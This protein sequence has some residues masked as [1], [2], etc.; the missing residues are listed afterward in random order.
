MKEICMRDTEGVALRAICWSEICPWLSIVRCFRLATTL[1]LLVFGACA[2]LFTL[3][4][5]WAIARIFGSDDHPNASWSEAF[6]DLSPTAVIDR[7]IPA[8]PLVQIPSPGTDGAAPTFGSGNSGLAASTSNPF[9]GPWNELTRPVW[10]IFVGP[11]HLP[12]EA[13][14]LRNLLS[15]ACTSLWSLAVWAYFGAAICRVAAVQLACE[16]RVGWGSALRWAGSKWL[17]Y[18]AAPLFP[19]CGV[20]LAAAAICLLGLLMKSDIGAVAVGLVW[21]IVL[22]GGFTMTM[23]LIGAMLGWPLMWATI[24]VEGTDSFDA[25]SRTYAYVFQRPLRYLFYGFV[26]SVVGGLGWIVVENFAIAVSWLGTWAAS[27]GSGADRMKE[28][29]TPNADGSSGS[30][31]ASII[32]FWAL[33]IKLLVLGYLYAFFGA[34]S[35][36]IYFQLRRDVDA[37]ETDEVFCD[38]DRSEKEAA[39][40]A[41]IQDERGAPEVAAAELPS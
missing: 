25:L 34:A 33:G 40:P 28:L 38:A 13:V 29:F 15:L 22:V 32:G 18:F 5:W 39:L 24:S 35:T 7:S 3:S 17:S 27:W 9:L 31:A 10:R 19:M 21:P 8:R 41:V 16:E 1:R 14:T 26:A 36:A 11:K 2:V 6:G 12:M 30:T 20:A 37:T 23:L 4:G